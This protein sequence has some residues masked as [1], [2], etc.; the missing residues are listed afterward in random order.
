[1]FDGLDRGVTASEPAAIEHGADA[2][3]YPRERGDEGK[4]LHRVNPKRSPAPG[5]WLERGKNQREPDREGRQADD[6]RC[7]PLGEQVEELERVL[8]I[9]PDEEE[10][11]RQGFGG[12]LDE[13]THG[14][15]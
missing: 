1:M 6:D 7:A 4:K 12:N 9:R 14:V 3:V 8:V 10:Y 13:T 11:Q 2:A 5:E 15:V